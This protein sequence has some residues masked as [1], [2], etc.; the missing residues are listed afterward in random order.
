MRY[1]GQEIGLRRIGAFGGKTRRFKRAVIRRCGLPR[2][3]GNQHHR[4][5][6]DEDPA[7][8]EIDGDAPAQRRCGQRYSRVGERLDVGKKLTEDLRVGCGEKRCQV[9]ALK[10]RRLRRQA[11]REWRVGSHDL[12]V[13]RH[14]R[15][16]RAREVESRA[17]QRALELR[18][19]KLF[20]ERASERQGA[21]LRARRDE[22]EIATRRRRLLVRIG[23]RRRRGLRCGDDE[24]A[25]RERPRDFVKRQAFARTERLSHIDARPKP[26]RAASRHCRATARRRSLQNS[27]RRPSPQWVQRLARD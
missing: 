13:R 26:A 19:R 17:K 7:Q 27:N 25:F 22:L 1:A 6:V 3:G 12:P 18:P 14:D 9:A 10:R 4:P 8:N 5:S 20:F 15:K 24:I 21:L 23:L 2:L 16:R 11:S